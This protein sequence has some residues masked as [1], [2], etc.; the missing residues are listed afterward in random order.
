MGAD[1]KDM[2]SSLSSTLPEGEETPQ[3]ET[4][5]ASAREVTLFYEK[6]GRG[7]KEVTIL[8]DFKGIDDEKIKE[9]ASRLKQALGAGG[10]CR[11]GEILIQG[12]R[13]ERLATILEKEGFK[14]KGK[15]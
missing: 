14:V 9:L 2:L 5:P 10:S 11:D 3:K 7:G 13:R 15:K 1:W 12:D 6:K 4:K 8:A